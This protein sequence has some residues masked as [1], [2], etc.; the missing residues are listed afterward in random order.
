VARTVIAA[1][2]VRARLD[3]V[4]DRIE[5]AGGDP[6]RVC[7]VAMTKGFGPDAVRASI[8]AGLADIGENYAQ[9]LLT[10]AVAADA[11][12]PGAGTAVRWHFVGRVQ[13]N[14]V[15]GVADLVHLWQSVDRRELADEIAHRAPGA[16]VLVQLATGVAPKAGRGGVTPTAVPDL[17]A[18]CRGVGLDVRGLMTVAPIGPSDVARDAFRTV[19]RLADD[20]GL[21]ERS[22]G[23]TGDFELAVAEGATM[24]R[25]GTGLFGPRPPRL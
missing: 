13:R 11:A 22:M 16:A 14:K 4:R 7:V 23:M 9:E 3:D 21:A 15:R 10:K 25:V 19:R 17:V 6:D 24:V 20:L 5:A 1:D 2:D 8:G 12:G 18:A